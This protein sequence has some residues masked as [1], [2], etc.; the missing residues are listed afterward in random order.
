MRARL[1]ERVRAE[2]RRDQPGTVFRSL[3]GVNP[4]SSLLQRFYRCFSHSATRALRPPDYFG[5]MYANTIVLRKS[6]SAISTLHINLN[7]S[8]WH[9]RTSTNGRRS[10]FPTILYFCPRTRI[11]IYTFICADSH[12]TNQEP[13]YLSLGMGLPL[14]GLPGRGGQFAKMTK[15]PLSQQNFHDDN[16][17]PNSQLQP[18]SGGFGRHLGY[19]IL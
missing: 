12:S 19:N 8:L 3:L 18:F 11:L 5:G 17:S 16:L 10:P 6:T 14:A 13:G 4:L 9:L 7:T 2:V 1:S 15:S